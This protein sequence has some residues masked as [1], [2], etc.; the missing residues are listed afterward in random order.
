MLAHLK[1]Y[2]PRVYLL[3]AF[4]V[5][6]VVIR[7]YQAG[8]LPVR[9]TT[10]RKLDGDVFP[11]SRI[12]LQRSA[13]LSPDLRTQSLTTAHTSYKTMENGTHSIIALPRRDDSLF[14]TSW[15][16]FWN[17]WIPFAPS[18]NTTLVMAEMYTQMYAVALDALASEARRHTGSLSYGDF[19]LVFSALNNETVPWDILGDF[20]LIMHDRLVRGLVGGMY[21]V[22]IY[23]LWGTAIT[24]LLLTGLAIVMLDMSGDV[25]AIQVAQKLQGLLVT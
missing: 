12:N 17:L 23:T 22:T 25:H 14:R 10:G 21:L 1:M 8:P 4:G 2:F 24:M 11:P 15:H 3:S 16:I 20:V 13:T 19:R 9:P 6:L 18:E 7:A 5:L